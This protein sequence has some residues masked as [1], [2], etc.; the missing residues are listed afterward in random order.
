MDRRNGIEGMIQ[1]FPS[2]LGGFYTEFLR[3]TEFTFQLVNNWAQGQ[4]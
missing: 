3:D 4:P 2:N 1:P